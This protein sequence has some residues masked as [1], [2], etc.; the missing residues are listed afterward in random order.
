V[1]NIQYRGLSF[2]ISKKGWILSDFLISSKE[3]KSPEQITYI[4]GQDKQRKTHIHAVKI[5]HKLP[6]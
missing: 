3:L 1:I 6:T 5:S 2:N 4:N